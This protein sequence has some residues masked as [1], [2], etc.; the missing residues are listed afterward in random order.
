M[1]SGGIAGLRSS[2]AAPSQHLLPGMRTDAVGV[3]DAAWPT[4]RQQERGHEP[5]PTFPLTHQPP[6]PGGAPRLGGAARGEL[7]AGDAENLL[8]LLWFGGIAA[9][10]LPLL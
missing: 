5:S 8:P 7:G 3:S 2:H 10:H 6:L 1:L 4:I 9:R